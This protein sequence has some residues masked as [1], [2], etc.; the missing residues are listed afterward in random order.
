MATRALVTGATGFLGS[1]LVC[2][3]L[4]KG[5][6]VLAT[7]R[8]RSSLALFESVRGFRNCS[9]KPSWIDLDLQDGEDLEKAF[10]TVDVVFHCAAKVSF[11]RA[12]FDELMETNVL[13]TRHVVNACL[14]TQKPLILASSVAAIGRTGS[15]APISE[16]TEYK[17]SKYNTDYAISKYLLRCLPGRLQCGVSLK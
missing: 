10:A 7:K 1:H 5:Y 17:E 13:G 9:S 4:D 3:L 2:T 15:S 12:D 6:E 8:E 11:R 14:K 16:D